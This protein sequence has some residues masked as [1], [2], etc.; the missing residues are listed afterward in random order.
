M[1]RRRQHRKYTM[2]IRPSKG[3]LKHP[4]CELQKWTFFTST[5][6]MAVKIQV[7]QNYC[8][9]LPSVY[10]CWMYTQDFLR[11]LDEMRKGTLILFPSLDLEKL[12]WRWS[13]FPKGVKVTALGTLT[14]HHVVL[15]LVL[16]QLFLSFSFPAS[17]NLVKKLSLSPLLIV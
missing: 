11:G 1:L 17:S 7:Y 8:M 13:Q 12:V 14:L 9:K 5:N 16:R 3:I 6:H 2:L 10:Q 4:C 15:L